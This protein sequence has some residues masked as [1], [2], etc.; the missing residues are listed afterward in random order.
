MIYFGSRPQASGWRNPSVWNSQNINIVPCASLHLNEQEPPD[1]SLCS[2]SDNVKRTSP[3]RHNQ[4]RERHRGDCG[5][6]EK[7]SYETAEIR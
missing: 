3:F 4:Q 2:L 1:H 5:L 6:S 7:G